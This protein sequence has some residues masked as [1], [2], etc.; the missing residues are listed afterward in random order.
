MT[1]PALKLIVNEFVPEGTIIIHPK[2]FTLLRRAFQEYEARQIAKLNFDGD[3]YAKAR[4]IIE[5]T[6]PEW[7][8]HSSTPAVGSVPKQ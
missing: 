6:T 4:D 1:L 3:E 7:E 8:G 5:R 2:D